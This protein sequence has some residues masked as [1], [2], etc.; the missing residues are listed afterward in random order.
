MY[1]KIL[2]I[3]LVFFVQNAFSQSK[4]SGYT[5]W[6]ASKIQAKRISNNY[7]ITPVEE[8][9]YTLPILHTFYGAVEY[10]YDFKMLR[11]S[12]GLSFLTLGTNDY[13]LSPVQT[14]R[15]WYTNVPLILGVKFNLP[16]DIRFIIES[17]VEL[18]LESGSDI[19]ALS[20]D[21]G[22]Y[23]FHVNAVTGIELEWNRF[24]LGSRLQIGLT[25]FR[26]IQETSLSHS[27]ITTY[28]GYTL[29]DS[30]LA[31]EKRK[32]RLELKELKR[33]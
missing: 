32:K 13:F 6:T 30:Q 33:K 17:G 31:K 11:F 2:I 15:T 22:K 1:S 12:T 16:H 20:Q 5:G 4:F 27:A 25:T 23:L 9:H 28:V 26:N 8:S 24:R 19:N 18:G 29:W 3:G 21:R 14:W 7:P 10:E